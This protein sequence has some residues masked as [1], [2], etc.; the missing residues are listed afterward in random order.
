[1]RA[2]FSL[3]PWDIEGDPAAARRLQAGGVDRV[4]LAAT[5]HAARAATP[6]HPLHRIVNVERSASYVAGSSPLPAGAF[7]YE[8]ARDELES[9]GIEVIPWVVLG[10]IDYSRM[11]IPRVEDAFGTPLTHAICLR[12]PEAGEYM[13][14][15]LGSVKDVAGRGLV[16]EGATWSGAS[17]ASVHDKVSSAELDL[18]VLSW[19]F[20]ARCSEAADVDGASVRADLVVGR[21]VD[22][23]SAARI[24][25]ARIEAAV[26]VR[27]Q[28][29]HRAMEL[30]LGE[31]RFHPD[32]DA[33]TPA[34]FLF[35]D[36]WAGPVAALHRLKA[37]SARGAY[38]TILG[39]EAPLPDILRAQW[40]AYASAGCEELLIYHAGLAS[41]PRLN[42]ALTALKGIA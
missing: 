26:S 3:F 1:M 33:E 29:A 36:A 32:P 5:Y 31:L 18:E 42:A 25:A 22:P 27:R 28:I 12:S 38:V 13:D 16:V 35:A 10:H 41:T 4:A 2:T 39:A 34:E 23:A 19:C 6:R 21:P 8:R 20:C 17:H 7:S 9:A 14:A 37:G 15:T 11:D 30:G 40:S 24:R